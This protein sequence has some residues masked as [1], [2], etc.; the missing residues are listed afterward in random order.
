MRLRANERAVEEL[1]HQGEHLLGVGTGRRKRGLRLIQVSER[2]TRKVFDSALDKIHYAGSCQR[3]GRCMRLAVIS[4][5]EWVGGVVLGSTFPNMAPRDEAFGLTR[6]IRNTRKRGLISPY[7]SENRLYWD[8]LQKIVNHAR[9]FI[10]PVFQG[11][12]LGIRTH[13]MLLGE[14]RRIW[15][16]KYKSK[17]HGFDTLCTHEKSRLFLENGWRLVGRTQGYSRDP[18]KALS[19]RRAFEEEWMNIKEN[20]GLG[21]IKGS[22]RWWIWVLIFKKF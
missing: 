4:G 22:R 17:V 18:K 10:F 11:N 6:F 16:R 13:E 9:T 1:R 15:E 5:S 21:R 14:G 20:A 2:G 19:A 7:A 8:N 3:V 12:G